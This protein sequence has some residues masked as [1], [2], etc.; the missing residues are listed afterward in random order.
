LQE[1][2]NEIWRE[3]PQINFPQCLIDKLNLEEM[4]IDLQQKADKLKSRIMQRKEEE[5]RK[6]QG[7]E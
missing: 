7:V 2:I 5:G 3:P 4:H 1:K 6:K